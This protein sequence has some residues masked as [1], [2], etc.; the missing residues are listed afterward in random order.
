MVTKKIVDWLEN[1]F[2]KLPNDVAP[3]T[4]GKAFAIGAAE[5][6]IDSAAL[7]GIVTIGISITTAVLNKIEK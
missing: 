4:L 2:D 5:G 7:V 3:S 1:K 6:V